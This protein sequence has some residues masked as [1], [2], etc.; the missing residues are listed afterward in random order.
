MPDQ[1]GR[2]APLRVALDATSL[3]GP[4]TGI[5][6]FTAEVL[7]RLAGR[8]DLRAVAFGVTWRGRDE[9]AGLVPSGVEVVGRPMAARPLRELWKRVDLPPVEWWTGRVDVVHGPNFV[10]PPTRHAGQV[11]TVHD[12]TTVHFPELC[13]ADTLAY[14]ALVRRAIRRG[15][16][17]HTVSD[18]VAQ[19]A[20]EAFDVPADRVVAIPNG[21]NAVPAADPADGH[22]LAGADRYLL[23]LG[24]IEPRKALPDLVAAFTS[25]AAGRPELRLVIAGPE[26]WGSD[27]LRAAIAGCPA[28][29]RIVRLGYLAGAEKASLLRGAAAYA[30]PSRYEGFGLPLLEA[31]A[32]DV[33]VVA[34]TA[35]AIPEVAGD[36][37]LLVPVGDVDA[38]AEALARVLD[39]ESFADG[40]RARGRANLTRFSWERTVDALVA[41]YRRAVP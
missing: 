38:L 17:V 22:R 37:A 15:A 14:P 9:L 30:Y 16:F 34:T 11:A 8:S 21:P 5:G 7:E 32:A 12:L 3:L 39:D 31:M 1:P 35:G 28:R 2:D 36:A 6:T 33:P 20:Q 23:A 40:L 13:T 27:D 4:R 24:T 41:L 29:D 10:V 18:F 26:G 19:E 25:L